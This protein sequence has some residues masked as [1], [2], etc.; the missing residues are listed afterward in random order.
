MRVCIIYMVLVGGKM[1]MI[2]SSPERGLAAMLIGKDF[3]VQDVP[4]V[5]VLEEI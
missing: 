4:T 3:A 1:D 2:F 5:L